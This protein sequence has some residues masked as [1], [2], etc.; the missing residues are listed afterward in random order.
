MMEDG[1]RIFPQEGIR[2]AMPTNRKI[3]TSK[4]EPDEL[5]KNPFP[6]AQ[7]PEDT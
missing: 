2:R 7:I 6:A 1:N 5:D 3:Q 4:T